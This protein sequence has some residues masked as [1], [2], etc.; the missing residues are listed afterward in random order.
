M[1]GIGRV[2]I[3]HVSWG[4]SQ[5]LSAR[6]A[7]VAEP[8]RAA[9]YV[10]HL[11]SLLLVQPE[12]SADQ[13]SQLDDAAMLAILPIAATR[14]GLKVEFD[15]LDPSLP[16]RERLYR[17]EEAARR[18]QLRELQKTVGYSM[19]K[20][21]QN[22]KAAARM[23]ADVNS[24][25]ISA[26][27]M[28]E[29]ITK[30]AVLSDFASAQQLAKA[31]GIPQIQELTRSLTPTM[32]PIAMERIYRASGLESP[33][34][35]TPTFRPVRAKP[36]ESREDAGRRRALADY[37]MLFQL[38]ESL[39]NHIKM[40]LEAVRGAQWWKQAV[41]Q[42]VR[43]SCEQRKAER[44]SNGGASNHPIAYAWVDDYRAIV[45]RNDNWRDC[46]EAVFGNKLETEVCFIWI[47][48]ARP[49]IGHARALRDETR[50]EFIVAVNRL[51]RSIERAILVSK[52][53]H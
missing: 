31:L 29:A 50:T 46:F 7:S 10:N 42:A 41:P 25:I 1:P 21:D 17:A 4:S 8:D 23:F 14:I 24:K 26:Q 34:T 11:I 33:L 22:I 53:S 51:L 15:A 35:H 20:F 32:R 43:D 47:G 9:F 37:D 12:M 27:P 3:G 44:E 38:E 36:T 45:L 40:Q 30:S 48:R 6:V 2:E 49:D 52:A 19:Q 13:V 28:L 16:P 5:D 39:R 18:N